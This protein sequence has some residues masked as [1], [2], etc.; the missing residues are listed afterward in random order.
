MT[1]MPPIGYLIGAGAQ[2]VN[3]QRRALRS[4]GQPLPPEVR[5]LLSPYFPATVLE[6]VVV[7]EV[8]SVPNPA[9][10]A[11]LQREGFEI[12][13]D[14]SQ[15]EGITFDD[16]IA[17]SEDCSRDLGLIFHECVHVTQYR[18]LGVERFMDIY[19]REFFAAA[20]R[21]GDP[22]AAYQAISLEEQAYALERRFRAREK[23]PVESALVQY[24][25]RYHRASI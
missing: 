25:A 7:A 17:L 21:L 20:E 10:Y 6:F 2:W 12:P 14:F 5:R 8:P 19:V 13:L 9:F 22:A 24:D 1:R 3:A 23:F 4:R 18:L 16:V 11:E 15:M